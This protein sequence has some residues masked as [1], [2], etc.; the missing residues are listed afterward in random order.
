MAAR[1]SSAPI[2][3]A[4]V[5][6][7]GMPPLSFDK[8]LA[9]NLPES[10]TRTVEVATL[11][12]IS[13]PCWLRDPPD[14]ELDHVAVGPL[15]GQPQGPPALTAA[16]EVVIGGRAFSVLRP[17]TYVWV[18]PVRG[19][20]SR[21]FEI[22]PEFTA[23]LDR[24]VVMVANGK[25]VQVTVTL[26]AGKDA[27]AGALQLQVPTGWQVTP[28]NAPAEADPPEPEVRPELADAAPPLLGSWRNV[29][30][31]VLSSLIMYMILFWILTEVYA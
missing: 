23:A 6:V 1:T 5:Q 24:P 9:A 26:A 17:V 29:Y 11:A 3:L 27:V 21:P 28:P 31:V 18:D 10:V 25:P 19:E 4:K 30:L 13:T 14:G 7:P 15:L 12:P 16:F 8:M 2:R 22:A 20:L